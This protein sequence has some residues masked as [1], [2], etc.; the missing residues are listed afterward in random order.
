M[1]PTDYAANIAARFGN[2][3]LPPW[4]ILAKRENRAMWVRI[5]RTHTTEPAHVP[6]EDRVA[7]MKASWAERVN[8]ANQAVLDVLTKPMT[9][10]DVARAMGAKARNVHSRLDAMAKDVLIVK[11]I[12]KGMAVWERQQGQGAA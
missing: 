2:G 12:F 6:A 5:G 3:K 4:P 9:S 1:T 11:R 7:Q 10:E 8:D